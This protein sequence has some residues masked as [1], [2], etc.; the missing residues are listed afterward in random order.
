MS[1]T[2]Q[3]TNPYAEKQ[4]LVFHKTA[5]ET[6]GE[7]LE[8][9]ACYAAEGVY[10]PEHYH[11][12][13]D[14]HF[15]VL[16]GRL[17]VRLNGREYSFQAG[18]TIDIPRGTAHTMRNGG[19][20]EAKV[21]WQVRPAM[22]TQAFFET[23][24]GL[25]A[26]GQTDRHGRPK[27]LQLAVLLRDYRD[28]FVLTRPALP[29][30]KL[31]FGALASVGRLLGYRGRYEKYSGPE[32]EPQ[33]WQEARVSVW[34]NQPPEVVFRFVANYNNDTRWRQGVARMTQ[35]PV[36]KTEVGTVTHEEKDLLGQRFVV[37]AKITAFEPDRR[38]DWASIESA[39]PVMGYRLVEPEGSGARF[40]LVIK[41]KLQGIYRWLAPLM[42]YTLRKEIAQ[43]I[44]KLKAILEQDDL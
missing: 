34:I 7:L 36:D 29:I 33:G 42:M 23:L 9:E 35:S 21:I 5:T 40:T 14:E 27:L 30:Q 37:I 2:K 18:Q 19:S 13:Q 25:A 17:Q 39:I 43:D 24:Y 15:E 11:P 28:E 16:K 4:Q 3:I 31:F 20:T 8:M 1:Q 41:G 10:P 6:N 26:D 44:L 38:L 32:V 12:Y 22:K